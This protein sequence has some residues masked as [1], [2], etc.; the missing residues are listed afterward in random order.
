MIP[1]LKRLLALFL[2]LC[3]VPVCVLAEDEDDIILDEIIEEEWDD[4]LTDSEDD[5]DPEAVLEPEGIEGEDYIVDDETGEIFIL[6]AAE[7][8]HLEELDETRDDSVDPESL[9][10]NKNL[11]DNVLNILLVG[12]DTR[13][14]D[15]AEVVGLGDTE[16]IVS[17]DTA[18]GT[19]KMTSILRDS[20]VT[21]PGYK[22]KQK[23]NVAFQRGGGA[24][25]MKTINYN[26]DMNIQYYVAI[27]FNGLATIIDSLGGIDIELRKAEASYI[28]SYLKK[29]P[30][31]YDN[32]AK[33][34][35]TSLEAKSGTQHL[36]GVQAVMYARIRSLKNENDFNRTDRQRHLLDLLLQLVLKDISGSRMLDLLDAC[37]SNAKTN[38]SI[39]DLWKLI[40]AML[41]SDFMSKVGNSDSLIEQQRIPLAK[42]YSYK[43]IN[44]SSVLSMNLTKN[45]KALHEFIYGSYIS[46]D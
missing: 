12:V 35:R 10:L 31:K 45:K 17:V 43:T 1:V 46:P 8:E 41:Q 7:E 28:N 32:K 6:T 33:G 15:S 36:D 34:E 25:A 5:D 26:F 2:V 22:N 20:Y 11:P 39:S 16:I 40:Q 13:S 37:I 14:N 42:S 23:I 9:H 24:L 44:G 27:N 3:L 19:L 38:M 30:P 21:I 29:H 18:A 4:E